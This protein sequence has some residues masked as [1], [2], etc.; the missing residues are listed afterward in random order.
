VSATK[1][2]YYQVEIEAFNADQ[3]LRKA[4]HGK[5]VV[6]LITGKGPFLLDE[7]NV[8]EVGEDNEHI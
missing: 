3:A 5:N 8:P 4:D 7:D 2:T 6:W 1:E